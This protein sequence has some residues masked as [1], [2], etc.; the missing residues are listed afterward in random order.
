LTAKLM[1]TKLLLCKA[2]Y[3]LNKK[4]DWYGIN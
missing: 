4:S 1:T 3:L 2:K